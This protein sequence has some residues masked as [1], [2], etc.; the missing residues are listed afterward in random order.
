[1]VEY[2]LLHGAIAA[3]LAIPATY[4]A[5]RAGAGIVE[6][7]ESWSGAHW[8]AYRAAALASGVAGVAVALVTRG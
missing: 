6:A 5:L 1:M 4:F 3:G 2:Q 7:A 8:I